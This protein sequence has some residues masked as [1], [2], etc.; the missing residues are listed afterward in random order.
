MQRYVPLEKR[1]KK[2]QRKVHAAR[3]ASWN[4]VD[5]VTRTVPNKKAYDRDRRK[6]ND[7]KQSRMFRDEN[8]CSFSVLSGLFPFSPAAVIIERL[9]KMT[10]R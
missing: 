9:L 1:S 3:R 6:Q 4:G 8:A 5:P 7:R 2:E 10:V